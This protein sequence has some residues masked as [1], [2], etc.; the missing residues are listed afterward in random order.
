MADYYEDEL[1]ENESENENEEDE[2]TK[3][4]RI[5]YK[6]DDIMENIYNNV[7]V[8][9]LDTICQ[10]EILQDLD[11]YTF[12]KFINFYKFNSPYYKY[13]LNKLDE[14]IK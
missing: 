8:P 10:K 11:E 7:I 5:E 3:Y 6:M 13:V 4:T 12:G 9:Y 14:N 1:I 2:L